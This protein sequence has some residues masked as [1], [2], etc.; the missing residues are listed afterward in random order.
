[1]RDENQVVYHRLALMAVLKCPETLDRAVSMLQDFQTQSERILSAFEIGVPGKYL[2]TD[3]D[4]LQEIGRVAGEALQTCEDFFKKWPALTSEVEQRR[5][6]GRIKSFRTQLASRQTLLLIEA[7][8]FIAP[9]RARI[10]ITE[11]EYRSD[12]MNVWTAH[13]IDFPQVKAHGTSE[14]E[15]RVNALEQVFMFALD[16][17]PDLLLFR[18][19]MALSD[20]YWRGRLQAIWLGDDGVTPPHENQRNQTE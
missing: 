3:L 16:D 14:R 6:E 5:I 19:R 1:M 8:R 11:P 10:R 4:D 12:I 2:R 7:I 18:A 17:D 20:N 9:Y 15:A 13:V